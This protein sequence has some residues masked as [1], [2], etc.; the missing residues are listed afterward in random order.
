MYN[1]RV[2]SA[3]G[4]G[5]R[6]LRH[7][8]EDKIIADSQQYWEQVSRRDKEGGNAHWRGNG[9]FENDDERWLALGKNNLSIFQ[10]LAGD[11]WLEQRPRRIIDWGSGGGANAVQFGHGAARYYGVDITQ[12]SLDECQRQ[13]VAADLHNFVPVL[14]EAPR[15]ECVRDLID[16][17]CDL[18]LSTY[19]YEQFPSKAY[20]LRV[21][22]IVADL[23]TPSGLAFIQIKY[24]DLTLDSQP[25]RRDYAKNMANMTTYRIEEFWIDAEACGFRPQAIILEPRQPLVRDRRYAYFLLQKA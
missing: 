19:V 16:E 23:L 21:L 1:S 13:M 24:R 2:G 5:H 9:V 6:V 14:F 25:Y 15:P 22:S 7:E 12:A 8:A 17:S 18:M 3:F 20:G 10:R 11:Q 4:A